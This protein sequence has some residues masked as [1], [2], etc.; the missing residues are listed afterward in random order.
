MTK[1]NTTVDSAKSIG[2]FLVFHGHLIQRYIEAGVGEFNLQMVAIYLFHMPFFFFVSGMFTKAHQQPQNIFPVSLI[3]SIKRLTPVL[4]FNCVGLLLSCGLIVFSTGKIDLMSQLEKFMR[5]A[6]GY[7]FFNYVTWFLVCLLVVEVIHTVQVGLFGNESLKLS[8][9]IFLFLGFIVS[10]K[11]DC[12]F[13][14]G[15]PKNFWF[16]ESSFMALFFFQSGRFAGKGLLEVIEKRSRVQLSLMTIIGIAMI[17]ILGTVNAQ[18]IQRIPIPLT[19]INLRIYGNIF[20]FISGAIIGITVL[21]CVGNLI[22]FSNL[23]IGIGTST[24]SLLGIQGLIHS[25]LNQRL[26]FFHNSNDFFLFCFTLLVSGVSI[27]FAYLARGPF[28][29]INTKC[30]SIAMIVPNKLLHRITK[31]C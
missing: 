24:L 28:E 17:L 1:R 18:Y 11:S 21:F 19:L 3:L 15:L 6:N 27:Y 7:P 23:A 5:L 25:Y 9:P 22:K 26:I 12:L 2:M 14:I 31:K 16:I 20:I 29:S 8:I 10:I 30:T 4:F 13:L